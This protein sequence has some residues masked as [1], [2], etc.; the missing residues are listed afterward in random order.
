MATLIDGYNLL[1]AMGLLGRDY[2]PGGLEKARRAM[3]G[4]LAASLAEDEARRTT[5]VFD[6]AAAPAGA[7]REFS[8]K[9]VAVRFAAN[10]EEADTLIEELILADS[11]PRQLVVVSSDHRLQ[12][13]ARRRR[14]TALDSEVFLDN[15]LRS[16]R[17]HP[18]PAPD[19]DLTAKQ[20]GRSSEADTEFWLREFQDLAEDEALE[21]LFPFED[22]EAETQ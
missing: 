13:A 17:P 16:R 10:H 7:P 18:A 9:N 19:P 1:H 21:E 4:L 3:L 15:L 5:V 12:R 20:H 11:A 14:A 6:A 8:Y 2:G 22:T